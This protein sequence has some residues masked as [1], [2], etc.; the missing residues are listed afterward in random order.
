MPRLHAQYT[1]TWAAQRTDPN[2]AVADEGRRPL[3]PRGVGASQ[4][5]TIRGLEGGVPRYGDP[6]YGDAPGVPRKG[7]AALAGEGVKPV[8]PGA[9]RADE[10]EPVGDVIAAA[11][12]AIAAIGKKDAA[13]ANVSCS[14]FC[15]S[16]HMAKPLTTAREVKKFSP[17]RCSTPLDS[18]PTLARHASQHVRLSREN[19]RPAARG[20]SNPPAREA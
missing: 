10:S 19:W 18:P 17:R 20:G 15:R 16:V 13:L 11:G 7:A 6:R 1:G 5:K 8:G 9:E 3:R 4:W 12:A 2:S 14:C